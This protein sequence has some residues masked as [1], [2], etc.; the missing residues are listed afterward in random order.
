MLMEYSALE[1]ADVFIHHHPAEEK[2]AKDTKEYI[3]KVAPKAKIELYA[4]DL[5]TEKANLEMVE[6]I[7]KWSGGEL[8]I[9]SVHHHSWL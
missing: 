3:A 8:H 2:D 7:K 5:R 9:L 4:A 1:G 6:A